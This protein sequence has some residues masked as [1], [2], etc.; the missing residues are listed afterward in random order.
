MPYDFDVGSADG[1]VLTAM[2]SPLPAAGWHQPVMV[3]AVLRSLSPKPDAVIVDGTAGTGGHSLGILPHVLPNGRLIALDRD[4]ESLARA[5]QRLAEFEPQVS[6][7]HEN[8]RNLP[9]ALKRLGLSTVDGVLLDLGMSSV[10]LDAQT[11]G[12]SFSKEGPLD[13]RMNPQR[14]QPAER[15]EYTVL[16]HHWE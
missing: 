1:A 14:G 13:M 11:R 12:F 6:C 15:Q 8:Y 2:T 9:R 7:L 5:G 4:A 3:E 16:A 10:Q